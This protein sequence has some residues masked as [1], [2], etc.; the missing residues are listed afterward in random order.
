MAHYNADTSVGASRFFFGVLSCGAFSDADVVV[1]RGLGR[2][3]S[4]VEE[5]VL[6]TA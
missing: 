6:T 4:P 2:A 1:D 3:P 5:F